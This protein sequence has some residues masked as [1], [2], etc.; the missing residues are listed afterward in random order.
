MLPST[1]I[2]RLELSATFTEFDLAMDRRRFIAPRVLRPRLV[3]L[4]AADVGKV[5]LESLLRTGSDARAPGG[6]YRRDDAEFTK[7][8]YATDEHGREVPLDDRTIKLYRDVLDAEQIH[9]QRAGDMVLRNYEIDAAAAIYDPSTWTG[10]SL[11]TAIT[12]EWNDH[13]NATPL[14]D[15]QAAKKK[16]RDGCGLMPNALVCNTRQMWNACNCDS[17]VNRL[18]YWGGEDPKQVNA[19]TLAVLFDLDYII[20]AGGIK[21]SA[22]E[23]Q[24]ASLSD[25]WNDEYAMVCR[26]A[27]TDDPQEPCIGRTFLWVEENNGLGTDEELALIVEEYREDGVRGSVIRARNDRDIVIMYTEAGHLLSNVIDPTIAY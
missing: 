15:V 21:N 5:T 24:S 11:T 4:Q 16:V 20:V 26:V 14:T 25:I 13:A 10:A 2:T 9:S 18:K 12:N 19:A 17:V 3:G 23:A 6:G 8:A 27:E 1:T 22:N 7:Y